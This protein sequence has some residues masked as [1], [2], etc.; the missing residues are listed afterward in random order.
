MN[1]KRRDVVLFVGP[2][3]AIVIVLYI[4]P[5]LLNAGLSLFQ[6]T[7]FRSQ[8]TWIGLGNYEQ[9][10][11]SGLLIPTVARSVTYALMS[12]ALIVLGP[13][14][15]ALALERNTRVNR[16]LRTAFFAPVLLSPLAVGFIFRAL[17]GIDGSVN[18]LLSSLTSQAV[19][20][21]WL[22]S[23]DYSLAVVAVS[24]AWR[25]APLVFVVFVAGLASIPSEFID[26]ARIDGAGRWDL[27]RYVKLP[28]L[29]P[30]VTFG[31]VIALITAL[32]AYETVLVLTAGGPGRST[33]ILNFLVIR[34]FG[35]GRYGTAAA[36]STVLYGA[37]FLCSVPLVA[38]LRRREVQL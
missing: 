35:E 20:I 13:L 28:L 27:F 30:A 34:E 37:I 23:T 11:R 5:L 21:P 26:A 9:L 14:A 38:L 4:G 36:L 3:A 1:L 22:A 10:D 32:S 31:V 2:A 19:R 24:V 16:I 18:E 33:Q 15:L 7:A 12:S 6:W 25:W 29:A 8:L 17:L